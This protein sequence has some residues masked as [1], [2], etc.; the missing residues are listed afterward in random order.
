[1]NSI[2]NDIQKRIQF[3][4]KAFPPNIMNIFQNEKK[5]HQFNFF[6]LFVPSILLFV[7]DKFNVLIEFELFINQLQAYENRK[8]I[9]TEPISITSYYVRS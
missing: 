2:K 3:I 9:Q 8:T 1:M 7:V 5:N 4:A 6:Q